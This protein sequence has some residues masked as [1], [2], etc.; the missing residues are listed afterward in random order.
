MSSSRRFIAFV[1]LGLALIFCAAT[2]TRAHE[3]KSGALTIR[4]PW[5]RPTTEG[6][7]G[8]A[9]FSVVNAGA[10]PDTLLMASTPAATRVEFHRTTIERGTARM[11]PAG[12][13][14]I[15]A[16]GTLSA[17]PGGL[18]LMLVDLKVPLARGTLV[19][20]VLTFKAA[21]EVTV[22]LRVESPDAAA[23]RPHH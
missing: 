2:A 10:K 14:L 11:R 5:S 21:G 8:V 18:H 6:M 20:L 23:A 19:P 15:T 9:Y 3:F 12:E 22:Q 4:H 17:E 7:P 16:G 13:L 1:P